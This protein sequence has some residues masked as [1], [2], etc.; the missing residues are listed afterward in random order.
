MT[1]STMLPAA[2]PLLQAPSLP[3]SG[4][5]MLQ[6]EAESMDMIF[7]E[8][9]KGETVVGINIDEISVAQ[10][11][12][13]DV[14]AGR[15]RLRACDTDKIADTID[16]GAVHA[17][18]KRLLA[19][20]RFRMLEALAQAI[21]DMLLSEFGASW[22]RVVLAKPRKFDDVAAVGIAIERRAAQ[23]ET[24]PETSPATAPPA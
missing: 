21:A 10:A 13:I 8:G 14:I 18:L 24:R 11:V 9:F 6:A 5:T 1:H 16:Y 17:G 7:I 15:S 20:H 12:R 19:S 23:P 22:V 3:A 2:G 4:S